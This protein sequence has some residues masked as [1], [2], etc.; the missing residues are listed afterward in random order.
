MFWIVLVLFVLASVLLTTVVLLQEPKQS[1]LG[2]GLT[3]GGGGQ[4]F[5]TSGGTAGGLQ[6]LTIYIGV[7]W[8]VL[9]LALQLI[10]R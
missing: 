9:A 6:R 5:A 10:P 1:G 2:D 4:D 7:A 3:G 8:G